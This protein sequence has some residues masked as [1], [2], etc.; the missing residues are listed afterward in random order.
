MKEC[1]EF[2]LTPFEQIMQESVELDDF[3]IDDVF[4]E[5]ELFDKISRK[6]QPVIDSFDYDPKMRKLM[7]EVDDPKR[8]NVLQSIK[9]AIKMII[10]IITGFIRNI[11]YRKP[12]KLSKHGTVFVNKDELEYCNEMRKQL[13]KITDN[14]EELVIGAV[15]RHESENSEYWFDDPE[16][17]KLSEIKRNRKVESILVSSSKQGKPM[18]IGELNMIL[19]YTSDTIDSL[20]KKINKGFKI[21]VEPVYP[22]ADKN[23]DEDSVGECKVTINGKVVYEGN[24]L[25]LTR[26]SVKQRYE[27]IIGNYTCHIVDYIN[28]LKDFQQK[29]IND[30]NSLKNIGDDKIDKTIDDYMI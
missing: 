30:V 29:L 27:Q 25:F 11:G 16:K 22:R 2:N 12:S 3:E 19:D 13:K 14:F 17:D 28:Y 23:Y 9:L 15:L 5:G 21:V 26:E 24:Q 4:Q 1:I 20:I 10:G 6:F 7:D 18:T 8:L